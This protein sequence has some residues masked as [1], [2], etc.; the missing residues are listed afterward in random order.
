MFRR[1]KF[2]I[3]CLT[4][5][6][7]A[8]LVG[9]SSCGGG[10]GGGSS[11]APGDDVIITPPGN[12]PPVVV[13]ALENVVLP[14]SPGG[15]RWESQP[16]VSHFSDPDGDTLEF[17]AQV[18]NSNVAGVEISDAGSLVVHI[19]GSAS[20]TITVTARD[21]GG[22]S[23]AQSFTVTT[24]DNR[25]PSAARMFENIALTLSD[26]DPSSGRWASG[27]L[28]GYFSDPEGGQLTY[29]WQ[30]SDDSV[31][32]ALV[33]ESLQPPAPTGGTPPGLV[34]EARSAGNATIT[35]T[36]TDR[37]GATAMQRLSVVVMDNRGVVEP[38]PTDHS[39]TRAGATRITSGQTVNGD[40]R[41]PT[42][43]DWLRL[44][45]TE[46]SVVDFQLSVPEGTRI[47]ILD[48][49]GNVLAS[50]VA[51]SA[52]TTNLG[53]LVRSAQVTPQ[54]AGIAVP[55]FLFLSETILISLGLPSL[56]SA[57]TWTLAA[58]SAPVVA[59]LVHK[60]PPL[61]VTPGL[62]F[63]TNIKDFFECRLTRND[64]N[65]EYDLTNDCELEL[66][67]VLKKDIRVGNTIVGTLSTS[68]TT[69]L[70]DVLCTAD[71]VET[72]VSSELRIAGFKIPGFKLGSPVTI[73]I[74]IKLN[75]GRADADKC[76]PQK[77]PGGPELSGST[78]P[79]ESV[80]ITLTDYIWDPRDG[81]LSFTPRLVPPKVRVEE[82]DAN[83]T[84]RIAPDAD[85]GET[86]MTLLAVS[87]KD[88]NEIPAEFT[89]RISIR[90]LAQVV[91][92]DHEFFR[93]SLFFTSA[94]AETKY[95]GS[96]R[97]GRANG[98]GTITASNTSDQSLRYTGEWVDGQPR[99]D[100]D[101]RI[102]DPNLGVYRYDGEWR[103]GQPNGQ[104]TGSIV[105]NGG[106]DWRYTGPWVGGN[107]HGRGTWT[108]LWNGDR[109][110]Y[111]G[112]FRN[113]LQHGRGE[114]VNRYA[115]G[116]TEI[117]DGEFRNDVLWNGIALWNGVGC[118]VV[119]GEAQC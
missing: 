93:P 66:E 111:S 16:L 56:T 4:L 103:N 68:G 92:R 38:P 75:V 48:L 45:I 105:Y 51:G 81:V 10:G 82:N 104:G 119:N 28:D 34:V 67:A 64:N 109:Y 78:S 116:D 76:R 15:S 60:L 85:L 42:D 23:A 114:E 91:F 39:D 117:L 37:H 26:D 98:Q 11:R 50:R 101:W 24:L 96:C 102:S 8:G 35:V 69:V 9:L 18:D 108:S 73:P 17:R 22:L 32:V 94:L 6:L 79:G 14:P 21:T 107:P 63:S 46:P 100:G 118:N 49:N 90:C 115:N 43:V 55:F 70:I 44:E 20:A 71:R 89:F 86:A 87:T 80:S 54:Q 61:T 77:I 88:R 53:G 52:A 83:W 58:V 57:V 99:G 65:R 7:V 106:N 12:R 72:S 19:Q 33:D 40:F 25:P 84:I 13:Q 2:A 112:E 1:D 110:R 59:Y 27:Y 36:A 97:N 29:Q 5:S 74:P 47:S 95:T 62:A 30:S 113:G 3:A 41:S 31:A